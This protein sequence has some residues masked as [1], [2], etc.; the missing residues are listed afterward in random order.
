LISLGS[1]HDEIDIDTADDKLAA[2][3][4]SIKWDIDSGGRIRSVEGRHT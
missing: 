2:Q 4:G 1:E 3:L